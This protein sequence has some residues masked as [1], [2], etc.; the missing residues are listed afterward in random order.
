MSR[1]WDTPRWDWDRMTEKL[2]RLYTTDQERDL[3]RSAQQ[4]ARERVRWDLWTTGRAEVTAC[5]FPTGGE[6][7]LVL[8]REAVRS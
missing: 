7:V 2:W 4:A 8:T 6:V 5:R 1:P 3:A